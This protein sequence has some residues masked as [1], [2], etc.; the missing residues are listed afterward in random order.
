MTKKKWIIVFACIVVFISASLTLSAS[1]LLESIKANLNKEIRL[2]LRGEEWEPKLGD[3]PMYPITYKGSTYLP[4]R[5][6]AEALQVPIRWD[7]ETRTVHIAEMIVDNATY[8]GTVEAIFVP[9]G[10]TTESRKNGDGGIQFIPQDDGGL[11]ITLSGSVFAEA[12]A[13]FVLEGSRV[14]GG[15]SS[16][17]NNEFTIDAKGNITGESS[18]PLYDIKI[19]GSLTEQDVLIKIEIETTV[20]D[21]SNGV[22]KGSK[23]EFHYE[24]TRI[25]ESA[26]GTASGN[27]DGGTPAKEPDSSDSQSNNSSNSCERLEWVHQNIPSLSGGAMQ[28]VLVPQCAS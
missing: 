18:L 14:D 5:S 25:A 3:T 16:K 8:V 19:A 12:D 23:L 4:V 20:D 26:P 21:E 1:P 2:M 27:G 10:S 7:E 28:L 13:S 6:V 9:A 24:L 22:G 11:T 17:E 15:W